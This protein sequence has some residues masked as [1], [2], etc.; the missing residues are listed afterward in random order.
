M[1]DDSVK[2]YLTY[3]L[4]KLKSFFLSKDV[5]SFLVFLFLSASFWFLNALNQERELTISFPLVYKG[6]PADINFDDKLPVEVKVKLKDQG[7]HL[8]SYIVDRPTTVEVELGE[9]FRE[10]GIVSINSLMLSKAVGQH[11]LPSTLIQVLAPENRAVRYYR[12]HARKVPVRLQATITP[13]DQFMLNSTVKVLPDSIIVY[14]SRYKIGHVQEVKTRAFVLNDLKDTVESELQL[15]HDDSLRYSQSM[16]RVITSAEMFTEKAVNIPVQIINQPEH[17]AVR[18]FPAEVRAVFNIAV[19]Q[20]RNF[21]P[22]DIQV[23]IDYNEIGNAI[24]EK[25][26]LRVLTHQPYISNVRIQPEEVEFL[27]EE[28]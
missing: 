16:V 4:L 24:V 1:P 15:V 10:Q 13:A 27:L 8:W 11:V 2:R 23:I 14:G 26:R 22:G 21:S 25:R 12:L 20:F 19:S 7:I 9:G 3:H 17:L 28:K 6:M 5:L 18:S